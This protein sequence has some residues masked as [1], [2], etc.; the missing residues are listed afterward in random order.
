MWATLRRLFCFNHDYII[1][2]E[3][4]RMF[5][6]CRYCA[7][8]TAGWSLK[9]KDDADLDQTASGRSGARAVVGSTVGWSDQPSS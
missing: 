1:S 2:A 7:R 3:P 8:R 4:G 6:R 9:V 5:L